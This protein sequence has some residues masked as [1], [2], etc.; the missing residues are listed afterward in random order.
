[1]R[2]FSNRV[3]PEVASAPGVRARPHPVAPPMDGIELYFMFYDSRF[4]MPAMCRGF[5]AAMPGGV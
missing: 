4:D 3:Q 1:M 5:F 2:E